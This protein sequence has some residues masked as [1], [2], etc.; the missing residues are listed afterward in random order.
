MRKLANRVLQTNL[1][2][3]VYRISVEFDLDVAICFYKISFPTSWWGSWL[4]MVREP[5]VFITTTGHVDQGLYLVHNDDKSND[6]CPL[7]K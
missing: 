2:T 3:C 5:T 4:L 7:S 6:P 1:L